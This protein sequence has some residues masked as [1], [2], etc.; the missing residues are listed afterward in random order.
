MSTHILIVY[1]NA[2]LKD[3][4]FWAQKLWLE[5]HNL[6]VFFMGPKATA[7]YAAYTHARKTKRASVVSSF[8]AIEQQITQAKQIHLDIVLNV[9]EKPF[10]DLH[11]MLAKR[12][13]IVGHESEALAGGI[14]GFILNNNVVELNYANFTVI[15]K[16]MADSQKSGAFT[17]EFLNLAKNQEM[18]YQNDVLITEEALNVDKKNNNGQNPKN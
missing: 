6:H 10:K 12:A 17:Q 5:L 16:L 15:K 7:Q 11:R 4:E 2:A 3:T 9:K 14:A 13:K 1:R 18:L 8:L